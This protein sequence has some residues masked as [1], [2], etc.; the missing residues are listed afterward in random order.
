MLIKSVGKRKFN[1]IIVTIFF[2]YL[3]ADLVAMR[4]IEKALKAEL[5]PV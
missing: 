2:I 1:K 4:H 3:K 5:G